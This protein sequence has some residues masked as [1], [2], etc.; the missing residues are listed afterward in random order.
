[1]TR[2]QFAKLEIETRAKQFISVKELVKK[3]GVAQGTINRIER[4]QPVLDVSMAKVCKALG[5]EFEKLED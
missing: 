1:M 5:I 3:A 2:E 4:A